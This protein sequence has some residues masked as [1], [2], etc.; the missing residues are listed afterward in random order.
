LD[1]QIYQHVLP[2]LVLGPSYRFYAQTP[3][4]FFGTAFS[5]ELSAR[6]FRTADSD[7]AR[8]SANRY[9]GKALF[10]SGEHTTFDISFYRYER[11]NDLRASIVSFGYGGSF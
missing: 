3:A 5:S 8:F 4:R 11:S 7:L 2:W 9:G 1:L 6:A 10:L